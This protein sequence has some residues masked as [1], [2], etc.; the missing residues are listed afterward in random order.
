MVS[1]GSGNPHWLRSE[2]WSSPLDP[3]GRPER[4]P[5]DRDRTD[6]RELDQPRELGAV[7]ERPG[8]RD[9]RVRQHDGADAHGRIDG[10]HRPPSR[11]SITMAS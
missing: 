8:R 4:Q 7:A 2:L 1:S 11:S 9:D 3:G 5:L 10:A 6:R